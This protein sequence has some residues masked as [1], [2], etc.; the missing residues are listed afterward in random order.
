MYESF[1]DHCI[2]NEMFLL[3]IIIIIIIIKTYLCYPCF[4]SPQVNRKTSLHFTCFTCLFRFFFSRHSFR[5]R[6]LF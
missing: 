1:Y 3:S 4:M 6:S 2:C 5:S